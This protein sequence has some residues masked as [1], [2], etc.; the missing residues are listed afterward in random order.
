MKRVIFA[1][2]VCGMGAASFAQLLPTF[3]KL[4]VLK[5]TV[6]DSVHYVLNDKVP[7]TAAL[8]AQRDALGV[9]AIGLSAKPKVYYFLVVELEYTPQMASGKWTGEGDIW[10]WT[11]GAVEYGVG[12]HDA[13]GVW[14]PKLTYAADIAG[15]VDLGGYD[16]WWAK[17]KARAGDGSI[18]G[19]DAGDTFQDYKDG[20]AELVYTAKLV[21]NKTTG[22]S[23]YEPTL[24][25][26]T[27][28]YSQFLQQKFAG[29]YKECQFGTGKVVFRPDAAMTAKANLKDGAGVNIGLAQVAA[30]I[31]TFLVK[32][33]YPAVVPNLDPYNWY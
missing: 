22:Q 8:A 4:V 24:S 25:S 5:G 3:T 27:I 1:L 2:L 21:T 30:D 16:W 29:V 15:A 14:Q 33:K 23:W 28:S 6:T 10:A 7:D 18:I 9:D 32:N 12:R 19:G 13:A 31:N 17:S 20:V 26:I 11:M